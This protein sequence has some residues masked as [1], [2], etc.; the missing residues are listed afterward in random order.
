MKYLGIP[1]SNMKLYTADLIYVGVKVEKWLPAWQGLQLSSRGKSILI[2]RSL[3]SL[4][5]YKIEIYL[6]AEEVHY[7]IHSARAKFYWDSGQK[8]KYHMVK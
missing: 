4:P 1:V 7:K 5:I 2:E 6:L 3:S 8:K